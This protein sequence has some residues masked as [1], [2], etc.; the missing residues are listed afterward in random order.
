MENTT[1]FLT[2]QSV[3]ALRGQIG[4]KLCMA[5]TPKVDVNLVTNSVQT[6]PLSLWSHKEQTGEHEFLSIWM[7]HKEAAGM[8][9]YQLLTV[10]LKDKPQGIKYGITENNRTGFLEKKCGIRIGELN[11]LQRVGIFAKSVANN[12]V[13]ID[14]D[15]AIGFFL[16]DETV[17][18]V[19]GSGIPFPFLEIKTINVADVRSEP[20]LK[21]CELRL[22][23]Q[24]T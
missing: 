20:I 2:D 8:L 22:Q 16:A 13:A 3:A 6:G 4:K 9:D 10:G 11:P 18:L 21:G 1:S 15:H 23:V 24:D 7:E 19:A 12:D 14:Y 5:F 17:C